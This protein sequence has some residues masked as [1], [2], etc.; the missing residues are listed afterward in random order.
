MSQRAPRQPIALDPRVRDQLARTLRA[1]LKDECDAEIG[2]FEILDLLDYLAATLGPH[3][4]N[5]GLVDAQ[6]VVKSRLD[7]VIEAI[8]AIEQPV[9]R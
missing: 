6:A 7:G 3:Y 8:E 1:H 9:P 2:A 4:Y 5:Q